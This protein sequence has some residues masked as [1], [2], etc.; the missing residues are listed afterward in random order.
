M[1][2]KCECLRPDCPDC[3]PESWKKTVLEDVICDCGEVCKSIYVTGTCSF[4][5]MDLRLRNERR[6]VRIENR[7]RD[8]NTSGA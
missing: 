5:G 6:V 2:D 1:R 8:E 3:S 7:I 4:C